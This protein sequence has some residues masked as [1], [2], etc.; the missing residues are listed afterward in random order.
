[1]KNGRKVEVGKKYVYRAITIEYQADKLWHFNFIGAEH[2]QPTLAAAKK[3]I[4]STQKVDEICQS[5][6]PSN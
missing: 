4:D 3:I 6:T 1:M 5:Q 2:T